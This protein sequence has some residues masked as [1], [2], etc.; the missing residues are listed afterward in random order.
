M[1]LLASNTTFSDVK[2]PK[3]RHEGRH[4]QVADDGARALC[5]KKYPANMSMLPCNPVTYLYYQHADAS[6]I[7]VTSP[8]PQTPCL[9]PRGHWNSSKSSAAICSVVAPHE[10]FVVVSGAAKASGNPAISE[11]VVLPCL[12]MLLHTIGAG[13]VSRT[14][15][16]STPAADQQASAGGHTAEASTPGKLQ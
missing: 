4:H 16:T 7:C 14:P 8:K 3:Q 6:F 12:T 1:P 15:A 13:A 10:R 2:I 9:H 5:I 11:H